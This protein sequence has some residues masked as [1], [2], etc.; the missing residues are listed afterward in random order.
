MCSW[1]VFPSASMKSDYSIVSISKTV[2]R[3]LGQNSCTWINGSCCRWGQGHQVLLN[4]TTTPQWSSHCCSI[5]TNKLHR[6][7]HLIQYSSTTC[8]WQQVGGRRC[9][10]PKWCNYITSG[11]SIFCF[12][13][14]KSWLSYDSQSRVFQYYLSKHNKTDYSFFSTKF[15]SESI[16]QIMQLGNS[17]YFSGRKRFQNWYWNNLIPAQCLFILVLLEVLTEVFLITL[18]KKANKQIQHCSS[19]LMISVSWKS[20]MLWVMNFLI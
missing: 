2:R 1:G 10:K 17:G 4:V 18:F 13:S 6:R 19:S 20:C 5:C 16:W 12:N 15:P 9:K 8:Y 14:T 11:R 7:F 3:A